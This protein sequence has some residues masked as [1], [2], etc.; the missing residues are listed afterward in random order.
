M[1]T[2]RRGSQLLPFL[3]RHLS[4]NHQVTLVS[5]HQEEDV[6]GF[7]FLQNLLKP[8][9]DALKGCSIGD[10]KQQKASQQ[11]VEASH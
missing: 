1:S 5:Y 8:L 2:Q 4:L 6:E 10:I 9:G 11:V 7:C 3:Q